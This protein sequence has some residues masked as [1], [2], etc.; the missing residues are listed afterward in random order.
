MRAFFASACTA[1]GVGGCSHN[2]F[3]VKFADNMQEAA[4]KVKVDK[5]TPMGIIFVR[6]EPIIR[7]PLGNV[8]HNGITFSF[9]NLL[10]DL[11]GIH[12]LLDGM[13]ADR[14]KFLY[15]E[16]DS[17]KPDRFRNLGPVK[18]GDNS[19][20]LVCEL[21][22]SYSPSLCPEETVQDVTVIYAGT[23]EDAARK[24][25]IALDAAYFINQQSIIY[26]RFGF[27]EPGQNSNSVAYSLVNAMGFSFPENN[28]KQ[29]APGHGRNLLPA[30]WKSVF[31]ECPLP[32]K[33]KDLC[34]FV[35]NIEDSFKKASYDSVLSLITAVRKEVY[36][37]AN[38]QAL[39]YQGLQLNPNSP[40]HRQMP[41]EL[42]K[43]RG[44][45]VYQPPNLAPSQDR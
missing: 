15:E 29:M 27:G 19:D 13:A 23:L 8:V 38:R 40:C 43:T 12:R 33:P 3:V 21:A 42:F 9:Y 39:P 11:G 30:N 32:D 41:H 45:N 34:D 37:D 28:L 4:E 44:R 5:R 26:D 22:Q 10:G 25:L 24:Y 1:L 2:P 31:E 36:F 6:S 20:M 16:I 17:G 14:E 7:T 18:L 35:V